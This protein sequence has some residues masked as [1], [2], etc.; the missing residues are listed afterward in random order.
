[1]IYARKDI[2][3]DLQNDYDNSA[4]FLLEI[5]PHLTKIASEHF[6]LR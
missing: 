6:G 3:F 4:R 5:H 1:M 2:Y